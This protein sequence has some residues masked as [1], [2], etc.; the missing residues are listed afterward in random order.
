MIY[1]K[2]NDRLVFTD[3]L[4]AHF[5]YFIQEIEG[6]EVQAADIIARSLYTLLPF[7]FTKQIFSCST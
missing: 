4:F 5:S 2:P 7:G 1:Q 3:I 6:I